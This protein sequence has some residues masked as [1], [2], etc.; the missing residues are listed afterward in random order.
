M[1]W[2]RTALPSAVPDTSRRTAC[3]EG[4][5]RCRGSEMAAAEQVGN[6]EEQTFEILQEPVWCVYVCALRVCMEGQG[7][8]QKINTTL[9]M[10]KIFV[11]DLLNL[12]SMLVYKYSRLVYQSGKIIL[13][14]NQ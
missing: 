6:E 14:R 3:P 13:K 10:G 1:W 7:G 12:I 11:A 5:G 8:E 4:T 9:K 2:L